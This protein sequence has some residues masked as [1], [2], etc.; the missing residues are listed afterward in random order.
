[1]V[2]QHPLHTGAYITYLISH[3]LLYLEFHVAYSLY[4][5]YFMSLLLHVGTIVFLSRKKTCKY[6]MKGCHVLRI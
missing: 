3:L 5:N 4:T 2:L 1:M 6:Y